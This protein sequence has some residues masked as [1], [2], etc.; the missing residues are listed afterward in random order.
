MKRERR[1][2]RRWTAGQAARLDTTPE[3]ILEAVRCGWLP[4]QIE[5][6]SSKHA[7][8]GHP[9]PLED[10][11]EWIDILIAKRMTAKTRARDTTMAVAF[12]KAKNRAA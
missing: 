10:V 9:P 7:L 3:E 12:N 6:V 4:V 11:S 8:E 1:N 5:G 2:A